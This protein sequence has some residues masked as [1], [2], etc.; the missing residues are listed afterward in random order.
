LVYVSERTKRQKRHWE[1]GPIG[2][3]GGETRHFG[4]RRQKSACQGVPPGKNRTRRHKNFKT[5]TLLPGTWEPKAK[6][7]ASLWVI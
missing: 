3:W 7:K 6:I 5:P 2:P 4:T 1:A